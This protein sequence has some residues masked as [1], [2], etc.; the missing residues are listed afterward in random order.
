MRIK[1]VGNN[2]NTI[3]KIFL[4]SYLQYSS[5]I[6]SLFLLTE[7]AS[8][9]DSKAFVNI[10][11]FKYHIKLG[12]MEH[13]KDSIPIVVLEMGGGATLDSWDPIYDELVNF[14]P[15]FAYERS[16]IGPSEWNHIEPTPLN[17]TNLLKKILN[18]LELNPPYVLVG[19]SWGGVLIR[20]FAGH[21]KDEVKA[22]VYIDPMD[23]EI[24]SNDER[25]VYESIGADPDK[26]IKFVEE[27]TAFF[28]SAGKTPPGVTAEYKV[29]DNF[30]K[31]D[32]Q[33]RK[34]GEEPNLP[35]V[36]FIGTKFMK[37]PRVPSQF[38]KPFD[39]KEWFDASMKQRIESLS[40]WPYA[41]SQEGY[42][43]ISPKATHYFH[44]DEPKIVVNMIRRLVEN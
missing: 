9:Q 20:T 38:E 40:K 44:F 24:T 10:D 43:F 5:W 34:L 12:G 14:A 19:H 33:D 6:L 22:L 39:S 35:M 42:L 2:Y 1:V 27:V 7:I 4:A 37:P 3:M 18:K 29:I 23:Y 11:G 36:V 31:S 25:E 21:N 30:V 15:V 13:L 16:G 17:V 32:V 41:Y 28:T 8:A 26:A